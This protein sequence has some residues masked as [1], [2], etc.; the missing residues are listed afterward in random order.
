MGPSD[1]SEERTWKRLRSM[2]AGK[3]AVPSIEVRNQS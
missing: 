2:A 3:A 1:E